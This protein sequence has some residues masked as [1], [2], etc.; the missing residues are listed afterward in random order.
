MMHSITLCNALLLLLANLTTGLNLQGARVVVPPNRPLSVGASPSS[1]NRRVAISKLVTAAGASIGALS[2]IRPASARAPGSGNTTEA[3]EQIRDAARD[4]RRLQRD[5]DQYATL[6]DEGM[7]GDNTA[8]A[9][10]IL[11]GIAPQAGTTAIETAKVTPI[12]RIDGAF[13]VVRK[14]AIA[15]EDKDSWSFKLDIASF[16]EVSERALF[17]IQKADGD[18]YGVSFAAKGTTQIKGIYK[19]AKEAIDKGIIELD[20]VLSLLRDAGAPG[21]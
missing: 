14:A 18:F 6:T 5:F 13:S 3:V 2:F 17:A 7:A 8:G 9:R 16:E 15:S 4:L 10:R 19:E 11:G 12:Y 20:T 21:L 1:C